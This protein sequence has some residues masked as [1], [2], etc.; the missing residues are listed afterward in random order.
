M[1]VML[2]E[3]ECETHKQPCVLILKSTL[4]YPSASGTIYIY[5]YIYIYQLC[6]VKCVGSEIISFMKLT[7]DKAKTQEFTDTMQYNHK[8]NLEKRSPKT[9]NSTTHLVHLRPPLP[10]TLPPHSS[11]PKARMSICHKR[12]ILWM[13]FFFP[14]HVWYHFKGLCA[15]GKMVSI[16]Q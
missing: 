1:F 8:T 4:S 14:F 12:Y 13:F 16:S 15:I 7:P 3:C 6:S 2:C 5:I 9:T 10:L 11:S